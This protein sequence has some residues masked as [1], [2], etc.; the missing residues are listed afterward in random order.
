MR[1]L[2]ALGQKTH[3]GISPADWGRG[4]PERTLMHHEQIQRSDFIDAGI[5]AVYLVSGRYAAF[6]QV[7]HNIWG[8]NVH[9]VK[10]DLTFGISRAF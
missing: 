3:D 2:Y 1:R 7:S 8:E 5:G 9:A 4:R 6:A 10:Y